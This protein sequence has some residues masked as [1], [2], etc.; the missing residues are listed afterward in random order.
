VAGTVSRVPV[1]AGQSVNPGD[2]L[3]EIE[4]E[5]GG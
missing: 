3:V 4:P 5:P 1:Q 2:V